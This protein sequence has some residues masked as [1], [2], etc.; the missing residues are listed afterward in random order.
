MEEKKIE[1]EYT[2]K[3][4]LVAGDCNPEK[5]LP[6]TLLGNR[7]IEIATVHANSWGIGYD[8]L[9]K[10][11]HAWVLSR[12]AVEMKRY[13]KVNE[14]YS[15]TTWIESYN[16]H[17]S[18]RNMEIAD[19]NGQ[20]IG[21][22]RT[23]WMIIDLASRGAADIER[24]GSLSDYVSERECPIAEISRLRLSA[25]ARKAGEYVFKYADCDVNRHVNTVRY[26]ELLL[27]QFSLDQFDQNYVERFE[28]AF[29]KETHY[30]SKADVM[31]EGD[32]AKDC[33]VSVV[34]DGEC[35]CCA[36]FKFAARK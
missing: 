34:V 17:F 32:E 4:F 7:V 10:N 1:K 31:I 20:T 35:H 25:D 3:F 33:K 26:V 6:L 15:L 27:N 11:N 16:R 36:R 22:V 29:N 2:Q 28:V 21:Y 14:E 23:V 13:P 30:G 24:Y 5:E 12:V 18:K 19:A 9:I 8:A